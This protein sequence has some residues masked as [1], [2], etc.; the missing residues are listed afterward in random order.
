MRRRPWP[1]SLSALPAHHSQLE[2]KRASSTPDIEQVESRARL[3]LLLVCLLAAVAGLIDVHASWFGL[4]SGEANTQA[5]STRPL[6]RPSVPETPLARALAFAR[7]VN[8]RGSD[9]PARITVAPEGPIDDRGYW[10]RFARCTRERQPIHALVAIHSPEFAFSVARHNERLYSTVGVLSSTDAAERYIAAL[11]G[12]RAR[13]CLAADYRQS[14]LARRASSRLRNVGAFAFTRLPT[15]VPHD[16]RSS[17]PYHAVALRASVP[18]YYVSGLG[19]HLEF[20]LYVQGL[21]FAYGRAIVQLESI[22]L[23][24][25]LP[26]REQSYL[27]ERLVDAAQANQALLGEAGG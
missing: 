18:A 2:L 10:G 7:A 9:V 12:R 13:A 5:G 16:Y 22:R 20:R 11:A 6:T 21:S 27:E 1:R 3:G 14:L 17:F 23:A 8:L 26:A 25:P 24:E 15:P 19:R 4:G